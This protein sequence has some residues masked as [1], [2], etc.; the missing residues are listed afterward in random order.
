MDSLVQIQAKES[1]EAKIFEPLHSR[2]KTQ[3][4]IR[5][6]TECERNPLTRFVNDELKG[7][8]V[9]M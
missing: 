8:G 4:D 3:V 5:K 6:Y 1:A 2:G 9:V 7:G